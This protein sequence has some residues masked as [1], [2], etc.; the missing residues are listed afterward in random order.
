MVKKKKIKVGTMYSTLRDIKKD[1]SLRYGHVGRKPLAYKIKYSGPGKI[2]IVPS[3]DYDYKITAYRKGTEWI[4]EVYPNPFLAYSEVHVEKQPTREMAMSRARIIK[5][6][7]NNKLRGSLQ[8]MSDGILG[9]TTK[10]GRY[11]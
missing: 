10:W 9:K 7:L 3:V 1:V 4:V 8:K 11:K 6:F 2:W 5:R